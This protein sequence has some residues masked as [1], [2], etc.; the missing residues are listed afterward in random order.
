MRTHKNWDW[1]KKTELFMLWVAGST[2]LS[3]TPSTRSL[4]QALSRDY[5]KLQILRR[6]RTLD[7]VVSNAGTGGPYCANLSIKKKL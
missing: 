1:F 7:E 2:C 4:S 5:N 3:N 6:R